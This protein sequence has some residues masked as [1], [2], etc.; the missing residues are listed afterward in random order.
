MRVVFDLEANGLKPDKIWVIVCHELDTGE[1]HVFRKPQDSEAQADFA[2]YASGVTRWYGHNCIDYDCR[3]VNRLLGHCFDAY[4]SFRSVT[5]TV[6]ASRTTNYLRSQGHGLEAYGE[7]FGVP[8]PEIYDWSEY[9]EE[10]VN[11]CIEDVRI[12]TLLVRK[13]QRFLDSERWAEALETEHFLQWVCND[14]NSNGFP[15]NRDKA[16]Q[17]QAQI[18]KELAQI[19]EGLSDAFPP[20]IVPIREI[21]PKETKHGTLNLQDFRFLRTARFS[22]VLSASHSG[23]GGVLDLSDYSAGAPFT[24]IEYTPFSAASPKQIVERLNE[25]GWKPEEKTKGHKDVEKELSQLRR[26][27]GSPERRKELE[28]KLEQYRLT[29]WKV[30]ETNLDTLPDTAPPAAQSLARRL[31]LASRR[32]TLQTWIDAYD[33]TT[34]CVHGKFWH[35]GAW[36]H[37]MAHSDPNLGNPPKFNP[38]QPDKTPYADDMRRMWTAGEDEYVVGVDAE[39]IQMRIF[40]H[41][42]EDDE[43]IHALV[44]GR[45]ED[46]TDPHSVNKRALGA[47][48]QSRDSAKTYYYAWVLGVGVDKGAEILECSRAEAKEANENFIEKYPGIKF[49]KTRVIPEDA[50]KGFFEGLDGRCVYIYGDDEDQRRHFAFAGYLQNGEKI[51][52]SRALRIWYP[53]LLKFPGFK[54]RNFVHD[55]WQFCVKRDYDVALEAANIVSDSIAEAGKIL[56]LRCPMAGSILATQKGPDGKPRMAIGD[57]WMETH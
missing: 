35:I 54:I 24:L 47:P 5:D 44:A 48:C 28:A 53:K 12:N 32:S 45:K 8:K 20:R 50:A 9:S 2:R 56:K 39:G 7:E 52:M 26:K 1:T 55:E 23:P 30:S 37:R 38:E 3:V 34:G 33:E 31:K 14:L 51:I 57:N 21:T 15:F 17:V 6:V 22:D 13:L 42:A 41:Y 43:L 19:D 25:A 10:L 16:L 46:G 49:I 40:A 27:R 11:R 4:S 18:E 36:T 29:G